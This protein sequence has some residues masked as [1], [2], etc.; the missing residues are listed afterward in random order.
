MIAALTKTSF[1]SFPFFYQHLHL[2]HYHYSITINTGEVTSLEARHRT[3]D[4][5]VSEMEMENQG[6]K[7]SLENVK[8]EVTFKSNQITSRDDLIIRHNEDVSKWT[9]KVIISTLNLI[10]NSMTK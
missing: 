3:L 6:L 4:E 9:Q 8:K 7:D 10:I 2:I 5:R 1:P